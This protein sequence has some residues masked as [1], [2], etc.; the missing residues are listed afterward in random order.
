M[1][2]NDAQVLCDHLFESFLAPLVLGGEM[3]PGKPIGGKNALSIGDRSPSNMDTVSNTQLARVR[4]ARRLVPVDRFDG[5]PSGAEWALAAAL[6]DLVQAT[7]PGFN[8]IFRRGGP[9]RILTVIEKTLEHIATARTPA[10]ALSR[11]TWFS[12]MFEFARTDT[13]VRWW[14]GS[15]TFLGEEP[16]KRLTAWPEIRRVEQ[17]RA[18]QRL[19]DLPISGGS[20][21]STRFEVLVTDILARTPLTDLATADR[22]SPAFRWQHENLTL[23]ATH[24]GR[25]LAVRAL[26][27]RPADTI[28]AVLGRAIRPLLI[29][30]ARRA[31]DVAADVLRDRA[32]VAAAERIGF[33][34]EPEPLT[35]PADSEDAELAICAGALVA[36]R[37]I[38]ETGGGFAES[39]RR[40]LLRVLAPASSTA[41]RKFGQ[42]VT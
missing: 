19:M 25:T 27:Q 2:K 41:V 35:P 17:T 3:R 10:E 34:R 11:H 33:G 42:L 38:G 12:R 36:S 37:W 39:E 4:V 6:H 21:D 13:V 29:K 8:T 40:L 32:L 30:K 20:V 26:G 15:E 28:D 24:A 9:R 22:A 7:H 31:G 1:A 5:T 23:C 18:S 14:T 16:P